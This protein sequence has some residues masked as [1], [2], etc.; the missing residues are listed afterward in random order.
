V[1]IACRDYDT[2]DARCF[3]NKVEY[4]HAKEI[5]GRSDIADYLTGDELDRI[6]KKI[7]FLQSR[8]SQ[9]CVD[10]ATPASFCT[11]LGKLVEKGNYFMTNDQKYAASEEAGYYDVTKVVDGDTISVSM[12]GT[13]ETIRMIGLDT[14]ETVDP[15][16]TVQCF[17][18]EA[19]DKAKSL[20]TGKKVRLVADESQGERDKYGRLLRYVFLEDGTNFDKLMIEEGYG[21]EHTYNLPY[22]YQLEFQQ[23]EAD[24]QQNKRGLWADDA[25]AGDTGTVDLKPSATTPSASTSSCGGDLYNCTGFSTHAAAQAVYDKCMT[26]VG[27]DV[28][29]LDADGNGVACEN[30]P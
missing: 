25:C 5:L 17:G 15:R 14:P 22:Q 10:S 3:W 13:T 19:S 16:K 24:A 6:T 23:A 7:G 12:N 29:R 1:G 28:H 26:E 30:L 11:S 9:F 21:H 2:T 8:Y 27:K 4:V 20:L 18:L